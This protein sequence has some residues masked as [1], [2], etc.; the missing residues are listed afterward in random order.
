MRGRQT[1]H[2]STHRRGRR[3][4]DASA[5]NDINGAHCRERCLAT[6]IEPQDLAVVEDEIYG[7]NYKMNGSGQP[8]PSTGPVGAPPAERAAA[9]IR[10]A[11]AAA[12]A[13]PASPADTAIAR[14][15]GR[16]GRIVRNRRGPPSYAP[17]AH[18]F[19]SRAAAPL[20]RPSITAVGVKLFPG[21]GRCC[22]ESCRRLPKRGEPLLLQSAD[23]S[24]Q[25]RRRSAEPPGMQGFEHHSPTQCG[26]HGC[27]RAARRGARRRRRAERLARRA[28]VCS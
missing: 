12:D 4:G 6:A 5:N 18:P 20:H 25:C 2:T 15:P 13:A 24:A 7:T 19:A 28:G 8:P 17:G 11:A 1:P 27:G 9:V 10:T 21:W 23:T 26:R 14:V 22:A 3:G 16:H